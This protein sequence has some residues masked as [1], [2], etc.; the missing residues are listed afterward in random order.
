MK[1]ITSIIVLALILVSCALE[2]KFSLPS[3]QFI[4]KLV[5]GNWYIEGETGELV[6][7]AN[8]NN[9]V[10]IS[11]IDKN[12]EGKIISTDAYT[13]TINNYK[14]INLVHTSDEGEKLYSF[15]NY[16]VDQDNLRF[17]GVNAKFTDQKFTSNKDLLAYF[18]EN[19][20]KQ[21][22]FKKWDG[23]FSTIK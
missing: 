9:T 11:I 10:S 17:R 4:D 5:I 12:G 16:R 19:I 3:D 23:K 22:F 13:S 7:T 14:I 2:S 8:A 15:Y 6:I 20:H 1:K 21:G 18:K